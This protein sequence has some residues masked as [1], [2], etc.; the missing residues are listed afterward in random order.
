MLSDLK[1][2]ELVVHHQPFDTT[3]Y[4]VSTMQKFQRLEELQPA[5]AWKPLEVIKRTLAATTQWTTKKYPLPMNNHHESRSPWNNRS[6]LMEEV[7]MN[8]YFMP[9]TGIKNMT[10]VQLF[11]DFM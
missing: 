10:S 2:E 8:T 3:C 6:R 11:L 5:L 1:W 4:A 9:V 7:G